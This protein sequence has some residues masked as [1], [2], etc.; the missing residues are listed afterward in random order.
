LRFLCQI[1]WD[2]GRFSQN[3]HFMISTLFIYASE[4]Y[5]PQFILFHFRPR[6]NAI[7]R[8][9]TGNLADDC[10]ALDARESAQHAY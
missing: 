1:K 6:F 5:M 8:S 3:S 7:P 10:L 2:P 4:E 9:E